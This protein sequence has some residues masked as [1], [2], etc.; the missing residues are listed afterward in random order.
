MLHGAAK[1]TYVL[2]PAQLHVLLWSVITRIHCH[3][4]SLVPD[5]A[6]DS[7]PVTPRGESAE[8]LGGRTV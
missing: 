6:C 7:G 8:P 4:A 2:S 5:G 3:M 1:S